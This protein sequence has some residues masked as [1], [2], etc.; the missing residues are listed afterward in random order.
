MESI[1]RRPV[2][3]TTIQPT[4]P[5]PQATTPAA[6][7]ATTLPTPATAENTFESSTAT[8]ATLQPIPVAAGPSVPLGPHSFSHAPAR[9]LQPGMTTVEGTPVAAFVR[10]PTDAVKD[11]AYLETHVTNVSASLEQVFIPALQSGRLFTDFAAVLKEQHG[12]LINGPG[13]EYRGLWGQPHQ[14]AVQT[15]EFLFEAKLR[16]GVL[17]SVA[18]TFEVGS[19]FARGNEQFADGPRRSIPLNIEW[20]PQEALPHLRLT[21]HKILHD[22]PL[23]EH[24]PL[25]LDRM[26]ALLGHAFETLGEP[27]ALQHLSD[28][29][30]V[31][32]HTHLNIRG[33]NSLFMSHVNYG[34]E[35][36]GLNPIPH[37]NLDIVAM[38]SSYDA[39]RGTFYA[40]VAAANPGVSLPG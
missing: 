38:R 37:K 9:H 1:S 34:L 33:N 5:T 20:L 14:T 30:H 36:A 35:R 32:S 2:L 18:Y 22:S 13:G 23:N 16:D 3:N 26:K 21:E 39:F 8:R 17:G 6:N 12:V 31:A 25:L 19:R 11:L 40:A 4:Q 15:G 29:F 10:H 27:I 28:Y 24:M 7:T